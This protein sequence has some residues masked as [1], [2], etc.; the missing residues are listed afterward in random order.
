MHVWGVLRPFDDWHINRVLRTAGVYALYEGRETIYLG[1]AKGGEGVRGMLI[2]HKDGLEG[3]CTKQATHFRYEHSNDPDSRLLELLDE[4]NKV[5]G[6][7]PKCNEPS[8]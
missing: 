5:Y 1:T 7:L 3:E 2:N 6:S 8:E 4:Y